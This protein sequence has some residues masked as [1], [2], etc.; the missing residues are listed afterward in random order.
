MHNPM[1]YPSHQGVIGSVAI[2]LEGSDEMSQGA[3]K[4]AGGSR[5][6]MLGRSM[7]FNEGCRELSAFVS[8]KVVD[9]H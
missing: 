9:V 1:E 4:D 8:E 5:F 6:G 2:D 3:C 7:L